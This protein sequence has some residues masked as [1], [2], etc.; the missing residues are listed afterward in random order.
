MANKRIQKLITYSPRL[1]E[2]ALARAKE[3]GLSFN[4]YQ[5]YVMTKDIDERA[6]L[7]VDEETE[8][9]IG[10]RLKDVER[11]DYITVDPRVPGELEK[12]LGL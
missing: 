5:R 12:A 10:E 9:R 8:K 7:M 6:I 3:L 4:E 2:L 1:Y 11:G